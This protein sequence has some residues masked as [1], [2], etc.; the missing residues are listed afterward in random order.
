MTVET[1]GPAL[2]ASTVSNTPVLDIDYDQLLQDVTRM[3]FGAIVVEGR[4]LKF[5][6]SSFYDTN[7]PS[8]NGDG[9]PPSIHGFSAKT[10]LKYLMHQEVQQLYAKLSVDKYSGDVVKKALVLPGDDLLEYAVRFW[11][12]HYRLCE[13]YRP[14]E[15]ALDFNRTITEAA[16]NGNEY[17]VRQLLGKVQPQKSGL[18]DA[19]IWATSSCNEGVVEELLESIGFLD[20]FTWSE[21]ILSR[22]AASGLDSLV[23]A[24]IKAGCN[25]NKRNE[26]T[27]ETAIH[28]AIA[29]GQ[30]TVVKLLLDSNV[31]LRVRDNLG[32]T[33]LLLSSEVG[34]PKIVQMLLDAGASVNDKDENGVSVVNTAVSNGEFEALERLLAAPPRSELRNT[35]GCRT[36]LYVLCH[37]SNVTEGRRLLIEK[38]AAPNQFYADKEILLRRAM[39]TGDKGME[40]LAFAILFSGLRMVEFLIEK[41]ASVNYD[42]QEADSLPYNAAYYYIDIKIAKLLLE[43]KANIDWKIFNGWAAL[44]A[45]YDSPKYAALFLKSGADVNKM[46][47]CGT[48]LMMSAR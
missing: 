33:P 31:D 28:T 23:S 19:I 1:L 45:A 5:S 6:H 41:G 43:H 17:I 42:P 9:N 29:W 32:R 20:D 24:L 34:L 7:I 21:C 38:G 14:T 8:E 37:L 11:A 35:A 15:L 16:R 36:P 25:L 40:P 12:E 26:D 39:R 47:D 22:A 2:A 18:Q 44:H 46:S 3:F 4:I 13:S 10:C 48:V 27:D 30:K